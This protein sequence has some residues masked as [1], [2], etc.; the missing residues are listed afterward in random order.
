MNEDVT[1][2]TVLIIC[3]EMYL[4]LTQ[5]TNRADYLDINWINKT[6][7]YCTKDTDCYEQITREKAFE[8]IKILEKFV[9]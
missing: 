2:H 3:D 1:K 4:E 8:I 5:F 9:K 7:D 6:Q